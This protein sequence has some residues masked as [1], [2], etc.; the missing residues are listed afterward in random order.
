MYYEVLNNTETFQTLI[1]AIKASP[2]NFCYHL[3]R[4]Q[5]CLCGFWVK[6]QSTSWVKHK[7]EFNGPSCQFLIVRFLQGGSELTFARGAQAN[8]EQQTHSDAADGIF[9]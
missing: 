2:E 1:K 4:Q 5:T 7:E 8:G 9:L 6:L 3:K